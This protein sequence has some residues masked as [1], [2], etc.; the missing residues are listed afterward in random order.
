MPTSEGLLGIRER[1]IEAEESSYGSAASLAS[2]AIPGNNVIVSP[3]FTQGFQ[4]VLNDG[5]D[6]RQVVKKVAGPLSLLYDIS[7]YPTNWRRLKYVFDIDSET[8]SNP[9]TH[10][11]SIGNTL[12]SYTA[13]HALQHSTSPVII[14]TTGNVIM[15]TTINF[16]KA[17]G[18]G[19]SGFVTV[20]DECIAQDYTTPTLQTGTFT[21]SGDPF[22]YRH[23]TWTLATSA[24]VE[25][26][27]GSI[28]F[29]QGINPLDS[30]YANTS[31]ARTIGSPIPTVFRISGR[32]NVNLLG[33]TYMDLWELATVLSGTNTLVFE[34]SA[35]NKIT[36]TL[37]GMYVEPVPLGETNINGINSADFVFT[38]TSVAVV[39]ID[40]IANW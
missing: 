18:E 17:S 16:Q 32:F 34:Q 25:V 3:K 40:A 9:Y 20:T 8:G 21:V 1:F 15:K 37:T 14:K 2:A 31:L 24:V 26:N 11:L 39:A 38:A 23:M 35:S 6:N 7:Y 13:E 19:N 5:S 4:E 27:N 36:M 29:D 33:S 12:K 10:T 28:V 22:Q 30:R